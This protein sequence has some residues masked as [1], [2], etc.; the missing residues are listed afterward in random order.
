M[1]NPRADYLPIVDRPALAL[2][3]GARV[4]VWVIV[5]VEEWEF[6]AR[7]PR[8]VLPTPQAAEVV[9]DV[10]N[11]S[12]HDYG[13]RVGFWRIKG[14]LDARAIK[15]TVSLNASV[16]DSYPAI[17]QAMVDSDWEIMGHGFVQR[18]LPLERHERAV[19]RKTL[20]TIEGFTG[21]APRGW[22]GP[23]LAETFETPDILV[24]E[25]IEYVCDWVNDD[26]PYVMKTRTGRLVSMPYTVELNDIP[27]YVVQH[28]RSPEIYE[29]G[30]DQFDTLYREGADS[31]R[32]MAIATH[33]YISGVPHRIKYLEMLLDYIGSQSEVLFWTGGQI[34]DWY[35]EQVSTR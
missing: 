6:R 33:P 31:A 30:R 24:E 4:V 22:M 29:R 26:Q 3:Q 21:T 35:N 14:L 32:V 2:P 12:W 23:G 11:Y 13:M 1:S 8:Q 34:L 27:I 10:P 17:V 18:P 15:S 28:H 20:A 25:G 7:M 19:V 9:P 5:N 16:C